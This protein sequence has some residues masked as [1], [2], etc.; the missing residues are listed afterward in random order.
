MSGEIILKAVNG[1]L[2]GKKF[3][4]RER[5]T[6]VL[7]R[8][9]DCKPRLPDDKEHRFVSRH[10]CL[11]DINPPDVRI[12][13]FGSLNGT[14][15]NGEK[16]GQRDAG[17][18]P[19]AAA[20]FAFRELDL[21]DGDRIR[22]GATTFEVMVDV[23]V[24][25]ASCMTVIPQKDVARAEAAPGVYYC[26]ACEKETKQGA[27][28]PSGKFAG[29]R[30]VACGGDIS[31]QIR[32]NWHGEFLCGAC[33]DDPARIVERMLKDNEESDQ[34]LHSLQG[35]RLER[36]IGRG[37]MAV[38]YLAVN[39][40]TGGEIALKVMLPQ[41]ATDREATEMFLRESRNTKAL[42]HPNVVKLVDSGYANGIFYLCLEYCDRGNVDELL[43]A[44]GGPMDVEDA[45]QI[46]YQ[47]L[48]GLE[49]AHNA[50]V[51]EVMLEGGKVQPGKG[52][53]HR[54][55]KPRNI[56]LASSPEISPASCCDETRCN[57]RA[58]RTGVVAKVGDYGLA[59]AF[60]LA[61]LSGQSWTGNTYGSPYY[62][63]RQQV[64]NFRYS[65]PEVDVW[66][67]AATL[68]RMITGAFPRD[69]STEGDPWQTVLQTDPLPV[70]TRGVE[71]PEGLARVVD[72]ALVDRPE[73]GIRSARE[74]RRR[75]EEAMG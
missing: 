61:G 12:R 27:G 4:F 9:S 52:L 63:P 22:V 66:A 74:L 16:I 59:K 15:V 57:F 70:G 65:R 47:V 10:H 18:S 29:P 56:F 58:G 41:V 40:E 75:L 62:I 44:R 51:P 48:D 1:G 31:S 14:F 25:C 23:P 19:E 60:D 33:R 42:D 73:I 37:G 34:P 54:D 5:D 38:V 11:L 71:I 43:Q 36:E 49:Y 3:R 72:E 32:P 64:V 28:L 8:A 53:V 30:C 6:C 20:A 24:Y 17:T 68:Y 45:L 13:D 50:D 39:E 7:G 21:Q 46:V 35:Y 2:A 55:I 67:T 69:F 26:G